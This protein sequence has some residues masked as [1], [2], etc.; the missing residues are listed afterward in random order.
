MFRNNSCIDYEPND[1]SLAANVVGFLLEHLILTKRMP[2]YDQL[3]ISSGADNKLNSVSIYRLH[4][5]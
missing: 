1:F 5:T 3:K 2:V 4:L